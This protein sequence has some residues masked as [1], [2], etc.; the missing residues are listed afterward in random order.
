MELRGKKIPVVAKKRIPHVCEI[1]DN[2]TVQSVLLSKP[3]PLLNA[4]CGAYVDG[5]LMGML[6]CPKQLKDEPVGTKLMMDDIHKGQYLVKAFDATYAPIG[7]Y[8]YSTITTEDGTE[9]GDDILGNRSL[10]YAFDKI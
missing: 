8:N 3:K 2:L 6:S 10:S 4:L 7:S 1:G 5:K 9:Y